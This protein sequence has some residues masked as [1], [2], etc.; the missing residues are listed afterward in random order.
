MLTIAGGILIAYLVIATI[1]LWMP[2]LFYAACVAFVAIGLYFCCEYP[3][4]LIVPAV[5]LI[6]R[7]KTV[8]KAGLLKAILL[9]TRRFIRKLR[10]SE[11]KIP[12]I[13]QLKGIGNLILA[14]LYW[15]LCSSPLY[16]LDLFSKSQIFS[17]LI[18]PMTLLSCLLFY[19]IFIKYS[20]KTFIKI[21]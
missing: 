13:Q 1:P 16:L 4:L 19:L 17:Y 9:V 12:I 3:V 21:E 2:V 18:V 11:A 8:K 5:V 15:A 6:N 10:T 7:N 20:H 14:I